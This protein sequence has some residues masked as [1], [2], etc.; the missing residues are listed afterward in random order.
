MKSKNIVKYLGY[1]IIMAILYYCGNTILAK[2]YEDAKITFVYNYTMITIVQLI[3]LGGIGLVLGF[4]R[5]LLEIK[6]EGKWK[7]DITRLIILGIPSLFFSIPYLVLRLM[8]LHKSFG[9]IF[10]ISSIVFGY[11]LIS[12]LYKSDK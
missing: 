6:N 4:D 7:F 12:S 2:Y 9:N 8:P 3:F 11:T 1:L 10:T 5:I